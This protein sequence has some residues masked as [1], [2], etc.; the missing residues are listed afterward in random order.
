MLVTQNIDEFHVEA[1]EDV[2][3]KY[4]DLAK[5]QSTEWKDVK[6]DKYG[7]HPH[8]L[9]IHGSVNYIRHHDKVEDRTNRLYPYPEKCDE[10]TQP[11]I[12]GKPS[13]PHSLLFDE[14]YNEEFYRRDTVL[15]FNNECDCLI[16]VGTALETNLA[17][18][19][20]LN[21][22][23]NKAVVIEINPDPCV[24]ADGVLQLKG[25]SEDFIPELFQTY[26]AL[27]SPKIVVSKANHPGPNKPQQMISKAVQGG[28][29]TGTPSKTVNSSMNTK[30]VAG[31]GV[32]PAVQTTMKPPQGVKSS[33]IP[34]NT[35]QNT[36]T[37]TSQSTKTNSGI[38]KTTTVAKKPG[39]R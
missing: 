22:I 24:I 37:N 6:S 5:K 23:N 12:E 11:L 27:K 18:Q 26:K 30:P 10:T 2:V 21:A 3:K 15:I 20:V 35:S 25:K 34:T 36:K 7:L 9:A 38:Q 32:K 39:Q 29:T 13:R 4:P 31:S 8:V 16:V 14:C 17:S 19:L 33:G 1:F 28:K